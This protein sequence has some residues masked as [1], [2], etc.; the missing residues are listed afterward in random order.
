MMNTK[1][2][3]GPIPEDVIDNDIDPELTEEEAHQVRSQWFILKWQQT[4]EMFC[5]GDVLKEDMLLLL[6]F[7]ICEK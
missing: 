7:A 6:V 3:S 5:F 2:S 4:K 1:V